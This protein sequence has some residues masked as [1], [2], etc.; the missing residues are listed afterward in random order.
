MIAVRAF[1]QDIEGKIQFRVS[2]D[3]SVAE[4]F[5]RHG[6]SI[7]CSKR[8]LT[9]AAVVLVPSERQQA[10]AS[11]SGA[12]ND[13]K[14]Q[15]IVQQREDLIPGQ[16]VSAFQEIEFDNEAQADDFPAHPRD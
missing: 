3:P 7:D 2:A 15:L 6:Y 16:A 9:R 4:C 1:A 11:A 10:R 14:G 12:S 8:M 5:G 13:G